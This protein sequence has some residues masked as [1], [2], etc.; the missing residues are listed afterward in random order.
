MH[1]PRYRSDH[2]AISISLEDMS[3]ENHKKRVHVF[4][5]EEC[6]TKDERCEELVQDVWRRSRDGFISKIEGIQILDSEFKEY[7]SNELR[8]EIVKTELLLKNEALWSASA[9]QIKH[10]KEVEKLH[11]ELLQKKRRQFGGKGVKQF[12]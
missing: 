10:H 5:F 9:D 12:R 7:R 4:R 6:W 11:A 1:L 2:S 3:F 8:K